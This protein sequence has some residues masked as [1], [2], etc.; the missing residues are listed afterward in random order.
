[1]RNSHRH[2]DSATSINRD[3]IELAKKSSP[4]VHPLVHGEDGTSQYGTASVSTDMHNMVDKLVSSETSEPEQDSIDDVN[5]NRLS[6]QNAT[7]DGLNGTPRASHAFL[8]SQ[9]R[10]PSME[11]EETIRPVLPSIW[12][13]PFAPL[14][15]EAN[16][17][18]RTR[19]STAHYLDS[20]TSGGVS[21]SG[22]F[23]QDLARQQDLLALQSSPIQSIEAPSSWTEQ[24]M[25]NGQADAVS[26]TATPFQGSGLLSSSE[27]GSSAVDDFGP[28]IL[29]RQRKEIGAR[30]G[31]IGE[32]PPS[33][34]Q[35]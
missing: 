32:T 17:S 22:L 16:S 29:N 23:R 31:V 4:A 35:G 11:R 24:P 10:A 13:T 8:N 15:G 6:L 20:N 30:F 28:E 3:D 1:M 18:P 33:G 5:R 12:N 7:P 26:A 2:T 25:F 21:S 14:P 27:Y 19:P 9:P 34:Q